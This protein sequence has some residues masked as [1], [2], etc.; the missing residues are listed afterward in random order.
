M[1]L[2]QRG[3]PDH[4]FLRLVS[5][6]ELL[7]GLRIVY[8]G[9]DLLLELSIHFGG[10]RRVQSNCFI[11]LAIWR[12]L[13]SLSFQVYAVEWWVSQRSSKIAHTIHQVGDAPDG[14]S[15]L[16]NILNS[17]V[18]VICS[19]KVDD[20][21]LFFNV[22]IFL[23]TLSGWVLFTIISSQDLAWVAFWIRVRISLSS[24]WIHHAHFIRFLNLRSGGGRLLEDLSFGNFSASVSLVNAVVLKSCRVTSSETVTGCI[25]WSDLDDHCRL[26]PLE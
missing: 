17:F 20:L 7:C 22:H 10:I 4:Y 8:G 11:P 3:F 12:D 2:L 24:V 15:R 1:E 26:G 19:F 9:S 14:D 5:N 18:N 21:C 6:E 23:L 13:L 25:V 16:L